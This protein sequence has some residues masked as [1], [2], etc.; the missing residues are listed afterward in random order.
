[1]ISSTSWG[2]KK[3]FGFGLLVGAPTGFTGKYWLPAS[4]AVLQGFIGGG[5][6]GVTLGGDYLFY[7]DAFDHPDFPFYVGP[8]LF[9]GSSAVGGPMYE[10]NSLGLGVR[11]MFGISYLF[12]KNPF[13]LSFELGPA[14]YLSPKV[15]M[16]IGGGI[17]FR[18]Y[19]SGKK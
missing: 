1:M 12:P 10:I 18:F 13:E 16:G 7:S 11:G 19:P 15:G 8:G 4:D 3:D 6:G 9:I 2:Q 14:L 5:F 17:A